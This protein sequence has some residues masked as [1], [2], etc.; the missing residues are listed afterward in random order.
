M[1]D[2]SWTLTLSSDEF[3]LLS[4]MLQ[5]PQ[6]IGLEDPFQGLGGQE[7]RERLEMAREALESRGYIEVQADGSVALDA[8]VA[9]LVQVATI[10]ERSVMLSCVRADGSEAQRL[11]HLSP[12]LL[13]EQ[14]TGT[15]SQV[16][17]TAVRDM[18]VLMERVVAFVSF[19]DFGAA[20]GP[21]FAL[22]EADF[23]QA[24]ELAL[25][26]EAVSCSQRLVDAGV[27]AV[28]AIALSAALREG[29]HVGSVAVW[30]RAGDEANLGARLGWLVGAQG[31]WLLRP[32]DTPGPTGLHFIP[33]AKDG[34]E[35]SLREVVRS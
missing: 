4:A 29:Q 10:P 33:A 24:Q 25:E 35:A 14:E 28:A 18:E 11:L 32:A 22:G 19:A 8:A 6:P 34:I 9:A 7:V 15:G 23:T 21:E 20:P 30:Q 27:P 12:E 2:S 5:L 16:M 17:L 13:L 1:A 31:G 26:G 3:F